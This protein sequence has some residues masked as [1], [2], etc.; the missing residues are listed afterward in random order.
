MD[1]TPAFLTDIRWQ[2]IV[3]ITL[4]SYILFRF[5]ALFRGT[6][7]FRVIIGIAVLWFFQRLAVS[8]GLIVTSWFIQGITAVAAIVIIVVF[9]N[10]L[11]SVLQTKNLKAI[12]WGFPRKTS[13]TPLRVVADTVF[14]LAR[15]RIGALLVLPGR[16]DLTDRLQGGVPWEGKLSREM[17]TSIFW[18]DNPV[19]DG[20]AVIEGDRIQLVGAVLPLSHRDDLP[21]EYGTRHRAALGLAES[22]DALVVVVSEERG[23]VTIAKEGVLAGVPRKQQLEELLQEHLGSDA[24][25]EATLKR[26]RLRVGAA[27]LVSFSFITAI[28]FSLSRGLDTLTTIEVP[29]EYMNRNPGM[30][31]MKASVNSVH[32]QL[33]GSGF[34]VKS[35]RPDQA[36]VRLDLAQS[37]AGPNLFTITPEDISLPPGILLKGIN[38]PVVEVTL[39]ILVKKVLPVQVDWVGKLPEAVLLV[40]ARVEPPTVE[41]IGG[42]LMLEKIQTVYTEKV[43]VDGI[44]G[45]GE[46]L[47]RIALEPAS[48]KLAPGSPDRVTVSYQVKRRKRESTG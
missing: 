16:E 40:G 15:R 44:Q 32:L 13:P 25:S 41:V 8:M 42:Q 21:T 34:L 47:A 19:H 36:R 7:L 5:Y 26:R 11:R 46:T 18:P 35:I 24:N 38:P 23:V 22:T 20:A 12:L 6:Q 45:P 1:M 4:N 33:A 9:R 10:E 28:W 29:V 2:D 39:D 48:L 27:A 3:D 43:A 37:V 30:E 31:I 14:E 17:L